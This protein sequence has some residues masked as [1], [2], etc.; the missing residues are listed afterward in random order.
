MVIAKGVDHLQTHLTP[1]LLYQQR[2]GPAEL[3]AT[4][5]VEE[6]ICAQVC[7]AQTAFFYHASPEIL[8]LIP[9]PT[10]NVMWGERPYGHP[11][12]REIVFRTQ[13]LDKEEVY[14]CHLDARWCI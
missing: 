13:R 8:L 4:G 5:R 14:A 2:M 3:L 9:L 11:G 1:I 10:Y 12:R 6:V 7:V